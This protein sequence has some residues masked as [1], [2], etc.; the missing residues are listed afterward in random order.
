MIKQ[1]IKVSVFVILGFICF[2]LI[3]CC[4]IKI[5]IASTGLITFND[6]TAYLTVDTKIAT[7]IEKNNFEYI[8]LEY[9]KQ[10][11]SCYINLEQ[12]SETSTN[13]FIILPEVVSTTETYIISNIII[14]SLNIY[15]YIFKK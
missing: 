6:A 15:E 10:Y 7:Y 8:K 5:D 3:I 12:T 2:W 14:D 11:F 13:Y 1:N 9:K 4:F